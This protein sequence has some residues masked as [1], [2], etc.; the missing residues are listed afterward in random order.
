M[1]DDA[2]TYSAAG[3]DIDAAQNALRS[4]RNAI[5]A[6]HDER[7]LDG[8]GGFGGLYEVHADGLQ[9]PILVSSIDGVGTKTAVAAMA[10]DFSNIGRDIVNHCVN[11]ILCQG[12]RPLF[13]MDYFGCS[14]LDT[15]VL[16][17]VVT[18]A[19]AAC[20][21]AGCAL[22]GGETAEMPGVYH[23]GESDVVGC[24]V[25]VVDYHKRLPSKH[26]KE[27]DRLVGIASDG[28]HTNGF[29]L[30]RHA[31]GG[32][33]LTEAM[34]GTDT[35]Y[36]EALLVPHRCYLRPLAG[37]I[38]D[39]KKVLALAHITGGGIYDNLPRALPERLGAMV[40]RGS[41]HVPQVFKEIQRLGQVDDMEMHRTFNMGVGMVAVVDRKAV[42][43][44]VR[45]LN[46]QGET[47]MDI[48]EVT[49]GPHEVT[50][51]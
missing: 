24:I 12:A 36:A 21:D 37:L 14:K 15:D 49:A 48:G 3:V 28:L 20:Q 16:K 17:Q 19:A 38:A 8:V 13:F 35:T 47:A 32:V 9:R 2:T 27:G 39:K 42:D 10:G 51:V 7:V 34:P 30:A 6:T 18:S 40:T 22:I 29:S 41:W 23:E 50:L 33:A 31:L 1:P 26:V 11:D 46:E 43:S 25:G 44:V 4:L 45:H 5:V